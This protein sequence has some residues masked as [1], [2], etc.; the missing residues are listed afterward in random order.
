MDNPEK[1]ATQGTQDE[2]DKTNTQ[3]NICR[4]LKL[5]CELAS[6]FAVMMFGRCSTKFIM[7][8]M[9]HMVTIGTCNRVSHF[10]F[11]KKIFQDVKTI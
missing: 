9:K 2:E 8:I 10:L 3:L 1:L 6:I 5:L 4:T 11:E 7:F